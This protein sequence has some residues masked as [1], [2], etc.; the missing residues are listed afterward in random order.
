[1]AQIPNIIMNYCLPHLIQFG[2]GA[3]AN[4]SDHL[5]RLHTKKALIVTDKELLNVGLVARLTKHLDDAAIGYVVFDGVQPNPTDRNVYD[6]LA[7]YRDAVCDTVIGFGGGSAMDAAKAIRVMSSHEGTLEEYYSDAGGAA[8]ITPN[9]P[10]S[11]LIPTTAGTGSEVSR[12]AIITDTGQN[13]KRSVGSPHLFPDV[14][15]LDPELTVSMP[16]QLTASTGMDALSHSVEAYVGTSYH[17]IAE[18]IALKA[19]KMVG[20][21]LR[22]AVEHGDDLNARGEMLMASA[23]GALAFQKGLGAI[24]SLA[25]QLST[26]ADIPHGVANAI[27][28]PPVMNFNLEYAKEGY[29]DLATALGVDTPG[30]STD[31]AAGAAIVAVT[32]LSHDV[33]M[34][35]SLRETGLQRNSLPPMAKNAMLDHC[36]KL[37]PRPCMEEDMLRLYEEAF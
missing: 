7:V 28:M 15:L 27:M 32:Q 17:P 33:G 22:T 8:K 14:A 26:E 37:N 30:M 13:R 3:I 2:V 31:E 24:H 6:G 12:G 1:M 21:N 23:M 20:E 10:Q 19:I 34:P 4:L 16:P 5:Q 25:H 29:A 36:Y 35:R 18:G 9:M 11:I